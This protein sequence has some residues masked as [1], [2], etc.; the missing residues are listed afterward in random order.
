MR[1]NLIHDLLH[2]KA[3]QW[4]KVNP[5]SPFEFFDASRSSPMI[6]KP[7]AFMLA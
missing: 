4:A 6:A 3:D 1:K 7:V 2:R 5:A